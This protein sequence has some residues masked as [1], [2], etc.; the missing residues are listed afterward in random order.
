MN[1]GSGFLPS[2]DDLLLPEE[3]EPNFADFSNSEDVLFGPPSLILFEG[4]PSGENRYQD[5]AAPLQFPE[6]ASTSGDVPTSTPSD[7]GAP[8]LRQ[9]S[10]SSA[11]AASKIERKAEQNRCAAA[12][13]GGKRVKPV[14]E[15]IPA[16]M[17]MSGMTKLPAQADALIH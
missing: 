15:R 17:L 13:L 7:Q 12:V 4:Q 9:R 3:F 5:S 8:P 11:K 2:L 10:G 1:E 6:D 16:C 14:P